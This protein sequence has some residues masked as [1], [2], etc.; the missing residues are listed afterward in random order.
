[1]NRR[2]FEVVGSVAA[3][4]IFGLALYVLYH[5]L[6]RYHL[7]QILA[8]TAQIPKWRLGLSL[9][10]A[11]ASY[12]ALTGYDVL[13]LR[14]IKHPLPYSKVGMTSFITYSISH[15]LGFSLFTG[16]SVRYRIYGVWGLS[17]LEI[18]SVMGMA[19]STFWLGYLS[20]SS[21]V[22]TFFPIKIPVDL[23]LP[24]STTFPVGLIFLAVL[25]LYM[26]WVLG[27]RKPLKF[28]A[29]VYEVPSSTTTGA[30]MV[31]GM[32]DWAVAAAALF[33]LLPHSL[34]LG[35]GQVLGI[36]LLAQVAGL[37]SNVP[38]G[39]GVF[40]T[41]F[42]LLVGPSAA[43]PSVVGS[44]IVYRVIYY[45]LPLLV[46]A[47]SL[48]SFEIRVR[49]LGS[50]RIALGMRNMVFAIV[51]PISALMTVIAGIVLLFSGATPA[52]HGRLSWLE[53]FLPLQV[54]NVSH[55]VGSIVGVCLLVLARG[56]QRRV[57][58][59]YVLTLGLLI[60][61][62]GASL[63]KGFDY[64]EAI[65][66]SIMLLLMLPSHQFFY[67]KSRLLE[68]QFSLP[69]IG[70]IAIVIA[71]SAWLALF[72]FKHVDYSAELWWQFGISADA[73]RS[74][75]AETG[76]MLLALILSF[77]A[78][79][80]PSPPEP[81]VPTPQTLDLITPI[82]KRAGHSSGHLALMG[83]KE[84]LLSKSGGAFIMY[85]VLDRSWVA[86][87]DPVGNRDEWDELLWQFH[88]MADRHGGTVAFYQVSD[89]NQSLY[90]DFGLNLLKLGEEAWIPLEQFSLD[91]H[92]NKPL[93]H[94]HR[95]PESEGCRFELLPKERV[96]EILPELKKISDAWMDYKNV[97]EKRFSLG[98]FDEAY[99]SRTPLAVVKRDEQIVAFANVWELESHEEL[100]IDLMRHLPD[101]PAGVMDYLI[102]E[103]MLWGSKEGYRW[104][105]LGMAPLSGLG[106][107]PV[108]PFWNQL[109]AF[110]FKHGGRFYNFQGL[111]M[112]KEKFKPVWK[113]RYLVSPGGV[114]A[115]RVLR[116]VATIISGGMIGV[117]K[118]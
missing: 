4:V 96:P 24:F 55:F 76:V 52:E 36:F 81:S 74:L 13:A 109:G 98:A 85:R 26:V 83:D 75:R 80:K 27:V 44:L 17:A 116:N 25:M 71:C 100:S 110:V 47:V 7:S 34:H 94:W 114:T 89:E 64:E 29:W 43:T 51:P 48:A 106:S 70:S 49:Q 8:S 84:I 65:V 28:K 38:G 31:L 5:Q 95:K 54:I 90:L 101:A 79:L 40:E 86:M 68:G 20:V 11:A 66:L 41:V 111:R 56:L 30:Q 91:G 72:S 15:N 107:Q 59:A 33:V 112:Y 45:L 87:G 113:P 19:V 97:R 23:N 6:E 118:K 39:L 60:V 117:V 18:T 104:F 53:D 88:D 9:L 61:G 102:I 105:N 21:L 14:H 32:L 22:M 10:F 99:L 12:I 57:D 50:S 16:G 3:I 108:A 62:I 93:R 67:R 73:S 63:L 92:A 115:F 69:W 78:F 103:L 77:R 42:L 1:M 2:L 58:A 46:A 37:V 35:Y 82:V